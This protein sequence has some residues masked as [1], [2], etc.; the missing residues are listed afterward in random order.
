VLFSDF[1]LN[2]ISPLHL[3]LSSINDIKYKKEKETLHKTGKI[4]NTTAMAFSK[5]CVRCDSIELG[6]HRYMYS[7]FTDIID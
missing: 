2:S 3:H 6:I 1:N 5:K 7:L 4:E